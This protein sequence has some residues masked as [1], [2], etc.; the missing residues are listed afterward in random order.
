MHSCSPSQSTPDDR[1]RKDGMRARRE[2]ETSAALTVRL[3][4]QILDRSGSPYGAKRRSTHGVARECIEGPFDIFLRQRTE[5]PLQQYFLT[6]PDPNK[7]EP[8]RSLLERNST[9]ILP[10][11]VPVFLAQGHR[12]PDH[13]ARGD[14]RLY[15]QALQV[16]K[17]GEDGR[18]AKYRSRPRG[19]G[20]HHGRGQ[21]DDGS[22]YRKGCAQRLRRLARRSRSG[23]AS[24]ARSRTPRPHC[25]TTPA[26]SRRRP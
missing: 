12:R 15:E 23:S 16:G 11:G 25:L 6:V 22:V 8:W 2:F 21:L 13:P 3:D 17:F 4:R 19:A 20:E 26:R 14:A 5:R 18:P 10:A 7:R 1:K 9:G 24:A